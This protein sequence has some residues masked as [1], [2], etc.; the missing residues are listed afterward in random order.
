MRCMTA[1]LLNICLTQGAWADGW[2]AGVAR[3]NITPTEPLW[4]SGYA[5]RSRPATDKLTDLWAKALV[6][7]DRQG[8]RVALIT[9][10]LVGMDRALSLKV[11]N[12]VASQLGVPLAHVAL[13]FSHTHSG[14]VVGNVLAP[15]Q[16]LDRQQREA[17][18]R[19]ADVLQ[20]KLIAVVRDASMRVAP[21]R[22]SWGIGRCGFA[23]NRRENKAADVPRLRKE[24]KLKGPVDHSAPVLQI[25]DTS[26]RKIAI[27]FGY[28]C[29]ATVTSFYQW[30][31][32]YPGFAQK[33]IEAEHPG[34]VALFWAGCGA[35]QNPLPRRSIELAQSYGRQLGE[36]VDSVL[37]TKMTPIQGRLITAYDE[38]PLAYGRAPSLDEIRAKLGSRVA[39][40]VNWARIVLAQR[41]PGRSPRSYPYPVQLWRLGDGPT[42][43]FLGGEVVVD[44]SLRL[45]AEFGDSPTWVAGYSNDVMNYVPSL[46]VLEEGGYEGLTGMFTY[47]RPAPWSVDVERSIIQ[48]VRRLAERA[49]KPVGEA[50]PAGSQGK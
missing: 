34:A 17:V 3:V 5:S 24:G 48:A 47:G 32:D 25:T 36:A 26:G 30:S 42:I 27:V 14:P 12:T 31:G 16:R 7:D 39:K 38:I 20:R 41:E 22:L 15:Q 2:S 50:Q 23:V 45:K 21:C 9:A 19:Y 40:E 43:V 10:D 8:T 35:D 18:N 33:A 29:H 37:K 6:L 11:R 4:M 49:S 28:A 46:R 13:N 1:L 44:Y